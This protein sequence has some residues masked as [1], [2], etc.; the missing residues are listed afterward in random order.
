[1]LHS[2]LLREIVF[3]GELVRLVSKRAERHTNLSFSKLLC[4]TCLNITSATV[5][6]H[7]GL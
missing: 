3:F 7:F 6:N 5:E 2:N 1:M 4:S